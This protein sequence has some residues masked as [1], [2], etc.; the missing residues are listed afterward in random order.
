MNKR[1]F[2]GKYDNC[3]HGNL[4]SISG[5]RG[6]SVGFEG[7]VCPALAPKMKFWKVW[8]DNIGKIPEEENTRYYI[9]EYYKTVLSKTD[10]M[11]VLEN[12][13]D[14]ILLC[15]EDSDQFCHRHV[16]A[17][18]IELKYKIIVPEIEVSEN[19]EI[20]EN[21]RPEYIMNMLKETMEKYKDF[22][23]DDK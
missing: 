22:D 18:Y 19:L 10:I 12:E 1:I 4:I 17:D 23:R 5:D 13:K 15:Y 11:K 3:K 16:L 7:K 2:T 9:E 8:H 21:K 20:T 6:K 14:P